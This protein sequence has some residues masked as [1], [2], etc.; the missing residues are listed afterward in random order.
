MTFLAWLLLSI[1]P[2]TS[3]P[4]QGSSEAAREN[5]A[6]VLLYEKGEFEKALK[7]FRHARALDP[8]S[9]AIRQNLGRCIL[10][11]GSGHL[12]EGEIDEAIRKL[13]EAV[14]LLP[15]DGEAH[16]RLGVA[17][18]REKRYEE[19]I[20]RLEHARRLLPKHAPAHL[21]LGRCYYALGHFEETI[22]ALEGALRLGPGETEATEFLERVRREARVQ[23]DFVREY[24]SNFAIDVS[25]EVEKGVLSEARHALERAY[26]DAASLLD[27]YPQA[28]IPVVLYSE[29]EFRV[30]T[31]AHD[32]VGGLFDGKIRIP[33]KDFRAHE[34]AIRRV[35]RHEVA[36]A[37]IR[38]A[39]VGVPVWF[40]EGL[41][42]YL[43]GT[44]REAA[45]DVAKELGEK[46][47]I[48]SLARI[49]R[50]MRGTDREGVSRAYSLSLSFLSHLSGSRGE[51]RFAHLAH[52]MGLGSS[53]PEA[54]R[55]TYGG[56]PA[57]RAAKWWRDFG[58][59]GE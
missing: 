43:D 16:Y 26:R 34:D 31:D 27:H 53:F 35:I 10:E 23:K 6:G 39:C 15:A 19:A 28:E 30:A 13:G 36:H 51:S 44:D 40:N 8:K 2:L 52:L 56:D 58:Q 47:K 49:S 54:F 17:L 18:H 59:S 21:W 11:I 55:D 48:P 3:P 1:L 50:E 57:D 25:G 46:G 33:L 5:E 4:L 12:R 24:S 32:W 29:K 20:G 41:A 42:Q 14:R 37:I 7:A 45:D 9:D 38:E 22:A